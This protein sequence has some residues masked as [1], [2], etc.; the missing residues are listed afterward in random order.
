MRQ[1]N[2]L[3]EVV[4]GPDTSL[5]VTDN[6]NTAGNRVD[7]LVKRNGTDI[8]V[9]AVRFTEIN[10]LGQPAE[11]N[12]LSTTFNIQ[13]F[14]SGTVTVY[15][16]GKSITVTN[17]QFTDSFA[18]NAVHIYKISTGSSPNLFTQ[19]FQWLGNAIRNI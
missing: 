3:V 17:G 8:W 4:L 2:E 18:P 7:T 11:T 1:T 9:F 15:D 16:E 6:S 14:T 19:L 12:T 10:D 13:G 5:A